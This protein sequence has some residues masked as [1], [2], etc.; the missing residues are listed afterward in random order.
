MTDAPVGGTGKQETDAAVADLGGRLSNWGRWGADDELGTLNLITPA[1]RA[2]AAGCVAD[3]VAYSLALEL[4]DDLPQPAGSGR[5]NAQHFMTATAEDVTAGA[6]ETA[7]ADDAVLLAVH[8]STHWDAL[9]HIFH[10]GVMFNGASAREVTALGAR[11]NSIVPAAR[12]L[13]ARGVLVDVARHHGVEALGERHAVGGDELQ[14]VLE[15]QKIEPE[16]G[17]VLLVRTGHL[18][19]TKREGSWQ[20]FAQRGAT[21]PVQPGL[22]VS[23]LPVLHELGVAALACDNWAVEHLAGGDPRFPFHE[24]ALVHMGMILGEMFELDELA[25]ACARDRR[26]DFMLAAAPLPIR[27]GVGGPA[28]PIAVR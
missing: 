7:G 4:R 16:P 8:G 11:R 24:V 9:S 27:G 26:Y 2:A 19:Q 21:M 20:A 22:D 15:A 18:G 13:V 5:L 14:G 10:D 3:G 6:N 1:R 12:R 17:D 23:C 28:N 25:A